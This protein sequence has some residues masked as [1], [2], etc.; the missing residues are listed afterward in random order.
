MVVCENTD[1]ILPEI[2]ASDGYFRQIETVLLIST[3]N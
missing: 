1:L 3:R 2:V